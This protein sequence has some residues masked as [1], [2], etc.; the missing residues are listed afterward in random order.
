MFSDALGYKNLTARANLQRGKYTQFQLNDCAFMSTFYKNYIY[1]DHVQ[2]PYQDIRVYDT[3]NLG[4]IMTI[5]H[6][7]QIT[8]ELEDNYTIDLCKLIVEQDKNYDHILI[9]GAGDLYVPSYLLNKFPGVKKI[10]MCEID[11]KVPEMVRKYFGIE[12]IVDREIKSGRLEL[13]FADGAE[14]LK[15]KI[16]EGF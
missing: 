12:E 2:S 13:V 4:R 9:I 16:Q 14:F 11:E 15:K 5:D 8:D 7:T 10:T 6:N 3:P 1:V